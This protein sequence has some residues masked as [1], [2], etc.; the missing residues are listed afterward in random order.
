MLSALACSIWQGE[1]G[2]PSEGSS[3]GQPLLVCQPPLEH[4]AEQPPLAQQLLVL[5]HLP[6]VLDG[7]LDLSGT[8]FQVLVAD[9]AAD[10]AQLPAVVMDTN[11][12]C[13]CLCQQ[14]RP[15]TGELHQLLTPA[16][17][18]Y[19]QGQDHLQDTYEY[20]HQCDDHS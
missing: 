13:T 8:H 14:P 17:R 1:E 20:G 3:V 10:G 7:L 4:F 9:G 6:T 16:K 11:Q 19:T 2:R 12:H 5:K 18:R 15:S